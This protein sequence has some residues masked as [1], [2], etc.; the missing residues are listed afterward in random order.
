MPIPK[1]L[2][3]VAFLFVIFLIYNQPTS[4]GDTAGNFAG[5]AVQLLESVG[6]FLT[7]LF[8]GASEG[9]SNV[10]STPT[11]SAGIESVPEVGDSFS[12]THSGLETHSHDAAGN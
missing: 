12:H 9:G 8:E 11:T 6:E 3:T 2:A 10:T 4:A 5:F 1:W 7:G